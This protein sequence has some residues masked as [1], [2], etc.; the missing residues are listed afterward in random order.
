MEYLVT[1]QSRLTTNSNSVYLS[2]AYYNLFKFN[3]IPWELNLCPLPSRTGKGVGYYCTCRAGNVDVPPFYEM[4]I[5]TS[6]G[7]VCLSPKKG[8]GLVPALV[9]SS[10]S[11]YWPLSIAQEF[12]SL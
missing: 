5:L 7:D 4:T 3:N 1:W 10:C 2:T 9:F 8:Q 6:H 11:S 12:V